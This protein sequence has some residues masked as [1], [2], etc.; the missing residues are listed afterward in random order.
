MIK[1]HKS[2]VLDVDWSPNQK[3]LVTGSCDFKCRIFSAYIEGIDSGSDDALSRWGGA[4]TTEFG[5]CIVEFDQAK[6][7]VQGVAW[8]PAGMRIAFSGHGSTLTFVDLANGNATQTIYQKCL[9][10][11]QVNASLFKFS[12]SI[13]LASLF[14]SPASFFHMSVTMTIWI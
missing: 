14:T 13:F 2:T 12:L 11:A 5:E 8:S 7:W 6:A 4:Q 9:P 10:T 1:K 3:F